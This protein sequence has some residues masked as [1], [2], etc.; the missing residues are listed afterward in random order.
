VRNLFHIL[1]RTRKD[2]IT[3][4]SKAVAAVDA[5][6]CVENHFHIMNNHLHVDGGTYD[7]SKI[8]KCYLI[9]AG[10]AT[11]SMASVIE[12]KMGDRI[13]EGC[14][15]VKYRHT[16]KLEKT[17]TIEAGHPVPDENGYL[18]AKAILK[19]AGKAEK[20]D[21][22][23]SLFSG[24]GSALL[25][26]PA[27]GITLSEKQ[28]TIEE[29]LRCGAAINEIN[30]IRKH[31]SGIKG[32]RLAQTS[33]PARHIALMLSDVVGDLPD[34]IA[35]GPTVPD[36]SSFRDCMEVIKKYD[37]EKRLPAPVVDHIRNGFAGN[38]PESP[39]PGNPV[40]E[41]TRNVVVG[42]NIN[43][44]QQA[45]SVAEKM[46]YHPIV[47]SSMIEGDTREVSRVHTAIFKEII[48][49]GNPVAPPACILS[50]GETTITVTGN[51]LGGRNQ[52][53]VLCA[54]SEIAGSDLVVMMSAGTDGTD[55]PTDAAGA[56]ADN[57][58]LNRAVNAGL[59]PADYLRN[60]DSYHFFK[61]LG[62]LVITG[63][64]HTNVMD[65]RMILVP[66]IPSELE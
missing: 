8:K 21:L 2:A 62:D 47:L 59:N 14:I 36:P 56:V 41:K 24:G 13:T 35:S 6:S 28:R 39:K 23:I 60:N 63:P 57:T 42:S 10:K 15:V 26:I 46:G 20:N 49:T 3:I 31:I 12:K 7:L 44:I 43:A 27:Q 40:F 54:V 22:V 48:R 45:K 51:G 4:F 65:I 33:Y 5:G 19:L 34:V 55:G 32:G 37:L 11:A 17:T 52:E 16:C 50:G 9:G 25:P 53:F 29:L 38:I 30:T 66:S 1:S 64:T 18:G 61:A 58:T